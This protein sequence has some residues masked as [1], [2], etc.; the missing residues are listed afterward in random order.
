MEEKIEYC[1]WCGQDS[2]TEYRVKGN[3]F[4]IGLDRHHLIPQ[5]KGDTNDRNNL[6]LLCQKCHRLIH[7][8]ENGKLGYSVGYVNLFI[9]DL[10]LSKNQ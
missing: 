1:L 3:Y 4:Y 7:R 10:L 2:N 5:S 6:V 8:K 9:T